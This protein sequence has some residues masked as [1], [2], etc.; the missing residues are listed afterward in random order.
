MNILHSIAAGFTAL[1]VTFASWFGFMPQENVETLINRQIS[2]EE[3]FEKQEEQLAILQTELDGAQQVVLGAFSPTGGGTYRL[4]SSAGSTDTTIRLSSFKEP[5]SNI[6]FTMSYIGSTIGYGTLDPQ[7]TKSEF[8]SFTGIT[9]NSDGTADLTGVSRGLTRTPA[10]SSCT[11]ST[12][13]ASFHPGQSIFILSDNPCL[14]SEYAVKRNNE[15]I[16]GEWSVTYPTASSS[17]ASQGFVYD[18][19]TSTSTLS[20]NKLVPAAIAGETI[21]QGQIV[22]FDETDNEWKLTDADLIATVDKVMLGVAQGS[23]TNGVAINGGVLL[24]GLDQ[25]QGGMT[26]GDLIY[27]SNTAGATSTTAGT[28]KRAIGYAS[29]AGDLYFDPDFQAYVS[30]WDLQRNTHTYATS[31]DATDAYTV[32]LDPAP[33]RY[34]TGMSLSFKAS[35]GN[36]ATSTLNVNGLGDKYIITATSTGQ[37]ASTTLASGH[38]K[39]GQINEV[40]YNGQDFELV[41][42]Q[43]MTRIAQSVLTANAA[44]IDLQNIPH[45]ERMLVHVEVNGTITPD[46]LSV[47]F[48]NDSGNNYS[49]RFSTDGAA[50]TTGTSQAQALFTSAAHAGGQIA[51]ISVND[52][53]ATTTVYGTFKVV[54][55]AVATAA[56]MRSEGGF[57]WAGTADVS[58]ITVRTNNAVNMLA[59]SR[60]T[61]YGS[62]E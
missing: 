50:D 17:I 2:L 27:L 11:A 28:R 42:P 5:V 36:T 44:T 4:R 7:T 39:A 24:R 55:G 51:E 14:F 57:V 3:R 29:N 46:Q 6:K 10:A 21:S 43:T 22:Y 56:P 41:I 16:T 34:V 48:N 13:L 12:T 20:F 19:M 26:Q 45:R 59:G 1:S 35:V 15:T 38:I 25:N 49:Y 31:T 32:T 61:V 18:V 60:V 37:T 30:R 58:R 62:T 47:R 52:H 9:Q 33:E 23:G 40:V 53:F 8:I 54:A